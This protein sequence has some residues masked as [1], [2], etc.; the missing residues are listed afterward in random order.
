VLVRDEHVFFVPG[1]L[2]TELLNSG[3]KPVWSSDLHRAYRALVVD[4]KVLEGALNPGAVIEQWKLGDIPLRDQY[5]PI[6]KFI[7]DFGY[8]LESSLTPFGYDWRSDLEDSGDAF[9]IALRKTLASDPRPITIIAHSMGGLV[10][11]CALSRHPDLCNH[12]TR[13]I[14]IGS[15]VR[16][17]ASAYADFR[18]CPQFKSFLSW[19]NGVLRAAYWR[20]GDGLPKLHKAMRGFHGAF[21][22]LPASD[23]VLIDVYDEQFSALEPRFWEAE[24]NPFLNRAAVVHGTI[25]RCALPRERAI[26]YFRDAAA[27]PAI[28][29]VLENG[30]IEEQYRKGRG[31]GTVIAYS[32]REGAAMHHAIW[33]DIDHPVLTNCDEVFTFLRRDLR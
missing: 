7:A 2:G 28:Y 21:Q 20:H 12:V 1:M 4:P 13:L 17:A 9:A 29:R 30:D 25:Q 24:Q 31:D 18:Q 15:P 10:A 14:Q 5:G 33:G 22:L 6:L 11:R 16:G 19:I 23:K 26:A 3:G 8:P 32:A 27:T